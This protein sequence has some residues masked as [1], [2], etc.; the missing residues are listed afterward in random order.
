M[1]IWSLYRDGRSVAPNE[2]VSPGQRLSWP[3]TIGMGAQ[4]V[5]AMA[6][7][8]FLV[9]A[10][11]G[12]AIP[13]FTPATTLFFSAVGTILFLLITK[14]RLPSYLGSS[15]AFIA[16]IGAVAAAGGT[17]GAA[18]GG[19]ILAG[20]GLALAGVA[21]HVAGTKWID[22]IM[23]PI[24]T[25]TIV[26]LIGLNLA[27]AAWGNFQQAQWTGLVTVVV[28]VVTSVLFKGF[29]GRLSILFGLVVGYIFAVARSE[30]DFGNLDGEGLRLADVSWFGAP[31]F[32]SPSFDPQLAILF[33]P[34]ILVLIAE[35]VGHVKTVAAMTGDNLD[36]VTGR[37]L[38]GDGAATA[39]AGAGGGS[40]TTTYAE[41]IGVMAATRIYSTAVYWVAAL[42]AL[43]LS[44]SP[45]VGAIVAAMPAGVLGGAGTVLY[46][47]I[48]VL[49][50]KIWVQNK[51]DFANSIN[52]TTA[53]IALVIGIA[54]FQVT[55]GDMQLGGIALGTFAAFA[56]YHSMRAIAK[57]RGTETGAVVDYDLGSEATDLTTDPL[58]IDKD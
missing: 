31:T 20:V 21:V 13:G 22:I 35:N 17:M 56:V 34:V 57:W 46:G 44:F 52:L 40:G 10:I 16:P 5:V 3:R 54:D 11:V 32:H 28:I 45:K 51:V 7:A 53:A 50:A 48:G 37:A 36:D 26:A 25:G 12:N 9:P 14:N 39:L 19:I 24:V 4:H 30:V 33:I 41:N 27:P 43:L 23:P 58:A 2:A 6:G 18:Q 47:L 29:L 55:I 8:T 42:V 49:G 1:A 38:I 15:F